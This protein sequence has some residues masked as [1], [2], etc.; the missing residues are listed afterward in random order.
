[1]QKITYYINCRGQLLDLSTP[2]VMG[3][4]NTTPDSFYEKSRAQNELDLLKVA[5]KMLLDGAKI[6]DIGGQSTRPNAAQVPENEEVTRI[7]QAISSISKR[8]P[9]AILSVD[10]FRA[11]VARTGLENGAHIINDISAGHFD[12]AMLPTVAAAGDV[13]F[14]AMHLPHP[15]FET[16]HEKRESTDIVL[17]TLDYFIEKVGKMRALGIRDIILDPGFG[18]GKSL[19]DNYRLL[20]NL[21][22]ISV[23]DCPILAGLSR[24]SMIWR[25]LGISADDALVGTA[26]LNMLALQQGASI[27]RVHDVKEAG[28]IIRLFELING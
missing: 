11:S 14:V 8:F 1:V 24:K 2:V 26:A 6:L 10:T 19:A 27:L 15:T 16:M 5:E 20:S 4:L 28:Q 25:P 3:I 7:E 17:E 23:V 13:P 22:A 21:H 9:T 12:A 18:F